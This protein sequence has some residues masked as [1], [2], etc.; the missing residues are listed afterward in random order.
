MRARAAAAIIALLSFPANADYLATG[1]IQGE[2]CS[3][4]VV[5]HSCKFEQVDAV[6]GKDGKLYTIPRQYET[7]S[8]HR[9]GKDKQRCWIRIKSDGWGAISAVMNWALSPK[10]FQHKPDGEFRK[11]DVETLYFECIKR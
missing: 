1:P 2:V 11:L 10:L 7:V 8:E 9:V 4:Y 6:E 5:Y 3:H